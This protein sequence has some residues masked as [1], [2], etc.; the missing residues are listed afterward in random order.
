[1][2]LYPFT[3]PILRPDS[4]LKGK[5]GTYNLIDTLKN[6]TTRALNLHGHQI[7]CIVGLKSYSY[8]CVLPYCTLEQEN[9]TE[10]KQ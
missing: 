9:L 7:N 8:G 4:V 2:S 1:M 6:R 5:S 3:R 10:T